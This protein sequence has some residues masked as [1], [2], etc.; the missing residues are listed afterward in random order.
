MEDECFS[1][2]NSLLQ[3]KNVFFFSF[4]HELPDFLFPFFCFF[5]PGKKIVGNNKNIKKK[6]KSE[7][8]FKV[9]EINLQVCRC[10]SRNT[11]GT[12]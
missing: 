12:T 9:K 11:R 8:K 4:F 1:N 5:F 10:C 3:V 6:K 2:S 7:K